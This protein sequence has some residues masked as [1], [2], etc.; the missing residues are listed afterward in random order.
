M[1]LQLTAVRAQRDPEVRSGHRYGADTIEFRQ[2]YTWDAKSVIENDFV[3]FRC[4][5][6]RSVYVRCTV[7][8]V[9]NPNYST[10]PAGTIMSA[11]PT[12][13]GYNEAEQ[14]YMGWKEVYDG[15]R[16]ELVMR[17]NEDAPGNFSYGWV[18]A[19]MEFLHPFNAGNWGVGLDFINVP[20]VTFDID[21]TWNITSYPLNGQQTTLGPLLRE[22]D[23]SYYSDSDVTHLGK[24]V[25]F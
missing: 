25:D 11:N 9:N 13:I 22:E 16:L 15:P 19:V 5:M 8:W 17:G 6:P 21:I 4:A 20:G 10:S 3:L 23:V 14:R 7:L 2:S 12:I 1:A 18:S 24:T